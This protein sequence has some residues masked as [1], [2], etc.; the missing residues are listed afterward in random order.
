MGVNADI[1]VTHIC[2][3][4][5]YITAAMEAGTAWRIAHC[6]KYLTTRQMQVFGDLCA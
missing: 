4:V 6:Q 5:D 2:Q 3:P 1:V